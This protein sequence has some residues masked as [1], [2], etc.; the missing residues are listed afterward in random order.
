M[1]K[2]IF[3]SIG[4]VENLVLYGIDKLVVKNGLIYLAD[5]RV[6]KI[7]CMMRADGQGSFWMQRTELC[8]ASSG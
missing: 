7:L 2:G 6:G 1:M 3:F 8:L 5:F 4:S